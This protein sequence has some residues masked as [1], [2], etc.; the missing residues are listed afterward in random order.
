MADDSIQA[1]IDL[2]N[3]AYL[4]P[5][6][7]PMWPPVWWTWLI[8]VVVVLLVGTLI[9]YKHKAYKKQAYRRE[10]L[11]VMTNITDELSD[12]DCIL[13]CHE[14]IRR[15]LISEGKQFIAALPSTSLFE[16][17][18]KTMPVKNTF[19]SLG[20]DFIEGPYRHQITLTPK[21]RSAMLIT[22]RHWIRKHHA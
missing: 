16:E 2:P 10:A 18:D 8:L 1:S 17:I 6:S 15:C 4:L 14:T 22:T 7:I 11:A 3:K 9:F 21:Q 13:L 5:Q 20:S 19:S 12:K